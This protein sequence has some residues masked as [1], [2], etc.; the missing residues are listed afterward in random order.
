MLIPISLLLI[1]NS[2]QLTG[3]QWDKNAMVEPEGTQEALDAK[4]KVVLAFKG[5]TE[6]APG[7][8]YIDSDL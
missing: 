3:D 6:A 5:T 4:G 8:L 2:I 7:Q 1:N